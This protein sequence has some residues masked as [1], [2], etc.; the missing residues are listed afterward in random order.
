LRRHGEPCSCRAA[1]IQVAVSPRIEHA[2]GSAASVSKNMDDAAKNRF[3]AVITVIGLVGAVVGGGW[4]LYQWNRDQAW[5]RAEKTDELIALFDH[6]ERLQLAVAA[7]DYSQRFV[8]Y[9]GRSLKVERADVEMALATCEGAEKLSFSPTQVR[10]RD[11]LDALLAFFSRVESARASALLDEPAART[12]FAYYLDLLLTLR[13]HVA[14]EPQARREGSLMVTKYVAAYG[15][16]E[17]LRHLAHAWGMK[18][19]EL[20][21]GRKP[22]CDVQHQ[23]SP[24]DDP[25]FAD[26]P[27]PL[28]CATAPSCAASA[29]PSPTAPAR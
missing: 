9:E 24:S 1:P 17:G 23:E 27:C 20:P 6:D 29:L 22:Q 14:D 7:L 18:L 12:Y 10:V 8:R 28:C 3:D 16:L 5:K 25:N 11:A 26:E 19:A 2:P 15:D 21:S 13:G 4:A